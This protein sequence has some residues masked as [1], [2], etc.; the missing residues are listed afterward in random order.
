MEVPL[1]SKPLH[2]IAMSEGI[3]VD[4]SLFNIIVVEFNLAD[5]I[6]IVLVDSQ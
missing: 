6:L 2:F 4:L 5:P 3:W 1:T